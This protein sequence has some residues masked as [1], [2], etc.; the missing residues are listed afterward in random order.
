MQEDTTSLRAMLDEAFAAGR[1]EK[2]DVAGLGSELSWEQRGMMVGVLE[3]IGRE[4]GEDLVKKAF[5]MRGV[6]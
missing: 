2:W 6:R 1:V 4:F 3:Q 5:E